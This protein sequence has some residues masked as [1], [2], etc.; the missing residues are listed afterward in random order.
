MPVYTLLDLYYATAT[1]TATLRD[2]S[3]EPRLWHTCASPRLTPKA[4]H[5]PRGDPLRPLRLP[6]R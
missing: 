4:L 1:T 2:R 5:L 3:D 6:S